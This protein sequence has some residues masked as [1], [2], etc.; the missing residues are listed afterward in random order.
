MYSVLFCFSYLYLK[1][2]FFEKDDLIVSIFSYFTFLMS[3][4]IIFV[5]N[6]YKFYGLFFFLINSHAFVRKNSKNLFFILNSYVSSDIVA[7]SMQRHAEVNSNYF[8]V[9]TSRSLIQMYML[10]HRGMLWVLPRSLSK[11]ASTLGTTIRYHT[12]L[13]QCSSGVVWH[14]GISRCRSQHVSVESSSLLHHSIYL[15]FICFTWWSIDELENL[16]AD[17]TTVCFE[18]W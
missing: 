9:Y 1:L 11:V 14:P 18:P 16:H 6:S 5:N 8:I 13:L 17:R 12:I 7:T 3:F 4:M 15:W 2:L 10:F